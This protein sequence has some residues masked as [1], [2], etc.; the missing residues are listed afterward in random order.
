MCKLIIIFILCLLCGLPAFCTGF[1]NLTQWD[2][3]TTGSNSNGGGFDPGV[4][5]PGTDASEGSPTAFTDLVA[6]TTT[7]T[8]ATLSFGTASPGNFIYIT[9]GTG[10][11][12]GRFEI[13]SQSAGTA[14][15]NATL[16][17]GTCSGN[18]YGPFLTI[19]GA[20]AAEVN[21]CNAV[22]IKAG[23]YALTATLNT[24]TGT[25][26]CVGLF[27]GYGTTHGDLA[28]RPALTGSGSSFNMFTFGGAAGLVNLSFANSTTGAEVYVQNFATFIYD[29][30]FTVISG[31]SGFYN[32]NGSSYMVLIGNEF[33][34][35]GGAIYNA[36][37]N[38][39]SAFYVIGNY[40]HSTGTCIWDGNSGNGGYGPWYIANNVFSGCSYGI[41]RQNNTVMQYQIIGNV[42]YNSTHDGLNLQGIF[43]GPYPLLIYNNIFYGNGGYG[44]NLGVATGTGLYFTAANAFGSNVSGNNNY[45]AA[46]PIA[47]VTLT[48]DPF[49]SGGGGN[50][51]LNTTAGGGAVLK[52]SGFPGITPMGTG[53]LDIGALQSQ[54]PA[55]GGLMRNPSLQ[56]IPQ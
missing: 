39:P 12:T 45:T 7:A 46:G 33:A 11:N 43:N 30:L 40:F 34:G 48:A 24:P 5:A 41:Y 53:Y 21:N 22:W 6:V 10:C 52:A 19:A 8:S 49:V 37:G 47:D 42:F 2:V 18:A 27:E 44:I 29:C 17:T 31:D 32:S 54:A 25:G 56:G 13:L 50:F 3:Q 38:N 55:G 26:S 28:S 35:A 23:A 4:V 20:I 15:F 51:A 16:G 1:G 36:L 14:T 9:G